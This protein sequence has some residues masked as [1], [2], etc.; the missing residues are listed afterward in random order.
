MKTTLIICSLL[1][2]PAGAA[3]A[4]DSPWTG[5]WKLDEAKSHLTGETVTFSKGKG[6]MLHYS[7]GSTTSY[8]FAVDGKEYKAW[9]NRTAAWTTPAKNSSD[10]TFKA[11]GKILSQAHQE[12]SADGKT[13]TGTWTGTRPDG[14]SFRE[15]DV[16]TRVSGSEGLLGTWR[17]TKVSGGG[18]PQQFVITS[19]TPGV[20]R[21]E[22]PDMK[23]SAEGRVDGPR[24]V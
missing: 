20:M 5:T 9:A 19:P 3:L 7:D 16:L 14:S 13:L 10:T 21:Y 15:V 23:A 24:G 8:D 18:G 2:M 22:V 1:A 4:A 17:S 12:L 6:E 11:D